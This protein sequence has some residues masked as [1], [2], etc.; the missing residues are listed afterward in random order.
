MSDDPTP[1][2][3]RSGEHP[4]SY[5]E[6][7]VELREIRRENKANALEITGKIDGISGELRDG[8]RKFVEHHARLTAGEKWQNDHEQLHR[9]LRDEKRREQDEVKANAK[10][11]PHWAVQA[12]VT[13]AIS[14]VTSGAVGGVIY[15]LTQ[16]PK[17]VTP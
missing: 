9:D 11:G 1:V 3:R 4:V 16:A 5:N 14:I 7:M 15:L 17:A 10:S 13:T 12:A 8:E 2:H 6:L